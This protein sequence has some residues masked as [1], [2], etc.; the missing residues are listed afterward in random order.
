VNYR[1][2]LK[3]VRDTRARIYVLT[4]EETY[5]VDRAIELIQEQIG[6][7]F[8]EVFYA[9][10]TLDP[11]EV[12]Q[13]AGASDLFGQKVLVVVKNAS[14]IRKKDVLAK[15]LNAPW[16]EDNPFVLCADSIRLSRSVQS[17]SLLQMKFDR[18][19]KRE[20][21]NWLVRKL[22]RR[23]RQVDPAGLRRILDLLP[24]RMNESY[25]ELEKILLLTDDLDSEEA[26]EAV[27]LYE[28]ADHS[29]F[30]IRAVEGN[31]RAAFREALP[32]LKSESFLPL[33]YSSLGFSLLHA[34]G[35]GTGTSRWHGGSRERVSLSERRVLD[36]LARVVEADRALKTESENKV[37]AFERFLLE[38]GSE[39]RG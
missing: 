7:Q 11:A 5:L 14:A 30:V 36:A 28:D 33:L 13:N 31:E 2:K 23:G 24:T 32:L 17:K 9:D 18:I 20:L 29:R 34:L 1:E 15:L 21:F 3:K 19:S 12:T 27:A 6:A 35:G 8:K 38:F 37:L 4:G 16:T 39:M 10:K 22:E 25:N 26:E